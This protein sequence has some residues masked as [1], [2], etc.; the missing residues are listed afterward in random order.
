MQHATSQKAKAIKMLHEL[1]TQEQQQLADK[2]TKPLA[3]KIKYYL[4]PVFGR[5]VNVSLKQEAG[6]FKE[7]LICAVITS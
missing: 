5:T 6:Q 4:E 7:F 2:L 1:F 3:E